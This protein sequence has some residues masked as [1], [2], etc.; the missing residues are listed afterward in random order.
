MGG[1]AGVLI[2]PAHID[3][4]C[5]K[6]ECVRLDLTSHGKIDIARRGCQ[7]CTPLRKM[8]PVEDAALPLAV[9]GLI[10][11]EIDQHGHRCQEVVLYSE[12]MHILRNAMSPSQQTDYA[13]WNPVIRADP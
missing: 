3:D 10:I 2:W 5:Q 9:P 12:A 6:G 11:F 7:M 4:S 8:S 13:T 1:S